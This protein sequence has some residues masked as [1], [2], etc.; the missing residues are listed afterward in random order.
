MLSL[1]IRNQ[2]QSM[3]NLKKAELN[4][5]SQERK[6]LA[7]IVDYVSTVIFNSVPQ[8]NLKINFITPQ[9]STGL[10]DTALRNSSDIDLFIGLDPSILPD[11]KQKSK[12]YLRNKI[13]EL[14]KDMIISWLIPV[15]NN[16]GL[17]NPVMKYAEHPYVSAIYQNVKLDIVFCF[18]ISDEF[19][20][21]RGPLTAVDR[22][23]HHTRYV[24]EHLLDEQK[25][26]VRVLKYL[27]QKLH[28]Y[29]D[30]SAVGRSGFIGYLAELFII[31]YKTVLNFME[32]FEDLENIIL[33]LSPKN[34]NVVNPYA[35]LNIKQIRKQYFP[36]DFLIIIDPTDFH[37]NVGSSVSIR[38]YR[39]VKH[40][41]KSFLEQPSMEFF[42][43]KP[44]PDIRNC[45]QSFPISN[46]FYLEWQTTDYAHYT[47]FR[48][49]IYSL[50]EKLIKQAENELTLEARFED[51]IGE[52]IFDANQGDYVLALFTSTPEISKEY[53]RIGPE[54]EAEEHVARFREK[55]PK[56]YIENGYWV[57]KKTRKFT[58]FEDFLNWFQ[59]KN[60][61]KYLSLIKMGKATDNEI[62]PLAAQSMGNLAVNVLPFELDEKRKEKKKI[63]QNYRHNYKK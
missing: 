35:N 19:L 43:F 41:F 7:S 53:L 36:N 10:K 57:T 5:T 24:L 38:A 15:F 60:K 52:L 32:H 58:H 40:A 8:K 14:F 33:F 3:I 17:Q 54:I 12:S 55:H 49:K 2:I 63:R 26:E 50:L 9:G 11:L 13:R 20:F 27:F 42:K 21:Q 46:F 48:D 4:P 44:L 62:S 23:P 18:D 34:P 1:E 37:R 45:H 25:D 59:S 61:I 31:K 51:V 39:V 56:S 16:A 30:K 22:S 6:K 28:C 29:G 47:K